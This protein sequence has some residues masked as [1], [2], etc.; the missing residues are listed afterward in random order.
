MLDTV[1]LVF[2]S[3]LPLSVIVHV[4]PVGGVTLDGLHVRFESVGAGGFNVSWNVWDA[5]F[6]LAVIVATVVLA[7]AEVVTLKFAVEE[8]ELTV[9]GEVT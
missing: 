5:P 9:T 6:K 3:A 2:V 7:T 4:D 1:T 8:P